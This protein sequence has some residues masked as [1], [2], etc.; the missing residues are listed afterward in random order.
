MQRDC[1]ANEAQEVRYRAVSPVWFDEPLV[2]SRAVT[3]AIL[4]S[5]WML[6]FALI[7]N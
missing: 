4:E 1:V 6:D 5:I 7:N 2:K 3:A